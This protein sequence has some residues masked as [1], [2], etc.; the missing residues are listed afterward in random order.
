MTGRRLRGT[1]R[2]TALAGLAATAAMPAAAQQANAPN[3]LLTF[4]FSSSLNVSDNYDL[5]VE[6]PGTSTFIDNTLGIGYR[7]ETEV[8]SLR[9]GLS[10]VARL[11]DLPAQGG[12]ASFDDKTLSF[13]YQR[14][15]ADSD[16]SLFARYN[17]SDLAFFD[18]LSVLTIEDPL[19]ENDLVAER[20]GSRITSSAG[21]TLRTGLSSPLSF[22]L[23]AETRQRDFIDV[24]DPDLFDSRTNSLSATAGALVSPVTRLSLTGTLS[25]YTADDEE[26]TDRLNRSLSLGLSHE[27]DAATLFS[28][29]LGYQLIDT[30]ETDI[31]G[32]RARTRQD[33]AVGTLGVTRDLLN[34]T[35]GLSF[36]HSITTTGGR[37]T[38]QLTR[39]MDLPNGSLVFA[40]G[41]SQGDTGR[42]TAVGDLS[43]LTIL[44]DGQITLGLSRSVSTGSDDE[45]LEVTR[46]RLGLVY[47]LTAVSALEL[48]ADFAQTLA[49]G[50]D[51]ID[52]DR[53]RLRAAYR[54]ALTED[55]N[56]SGGYE[57]TVTRREG[58]DN[59]DENSLF[60]TIGRSFAF[61]P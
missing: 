51:G 15:G 17:S 34:G 28:G 13:E 4:N 32:Q 6:K 25:D 9:F 57:Y 26:Q 50:D 11:A 14:F 31:F 45:E 8:Q 41:A 39:D 54:H 42:P 5:S 10:G 40:I 22:S 46:L 2:R 12:E 36:A 48:N 1:W 59:A 44:P 52:R 7:T 30:D 37:S 29:S 47:N 61:R 43:Y 55:W 58:L 53:G 35:I 21:I 20:T 33:G 19:D 38:L 56:L 16:L 49:I 27:T 23:S 24:N 3:P 18:P 60:L